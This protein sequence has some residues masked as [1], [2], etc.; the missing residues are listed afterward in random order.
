MK[1]FSMWE[2]LPI[3]CILTSKKGAIIDVNPSAEIYLKTAKK[4]LLNKT[5]HEVFRSDIDFLKH[6]ESFSKNQGNLKF[7]SIFIQVNEEM[8]LSDI[9]VVPFDC[10]FL[11]MLE[12]DN[13]KN[14]RDV[15]LTK[16]ATQSVVGMAEML[17]HEIKNPIA[18]ITGAAQ[19]LEMSLSSVDRKLTGLIVKETKRI[20]NL[21]EQFD[22]F[23]DLRKP[24]LKKINIHDVLENVKNLSKV[25]LEKNISFSDDYDPSLPLTL[26]DRVQLEQVFI[27][28]IDNSA[29]ALKNI[30]NGVITFRTFFEKGL[31]ILTSEG[32]KKELPLQIEVEDNGAGISPALLEK[33]FDPFISG[34]INGTGL[35]LSLVSKI[36]LSHN[37]LIS[38]TSKKNK[39]KVK[40]A[41]PIFLDK[42]K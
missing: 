33:I 35:G 34:S 13:N 14:F 6:F 1:K 23:G 36:I 28:L 41:M 10:N 21:I 2:I 38:I 7:K 17:A 26:G 15:V 4:N 24:E 20:M 11:I 30:D 40:I 32:I 31:S 5:M 22:K 16:N 3:S 12:A 37:G 9:W 42:V 29:H 18:G 27:N 39:T 19:L 8:I 25:N